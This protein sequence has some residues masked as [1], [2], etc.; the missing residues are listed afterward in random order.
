M[1]P[2]S[3]S[4]L[5]WP[6]SWNSSGPAARGAT[7]PT[8]QL[9]LATPLVLACQP[10]FALDGASAGLSSDAIQ[11]KE[12]LLEHAREYAHTILH[13]LHIPGLEERPLLRAIAQ[14]IRSVKKSKRPR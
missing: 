4:L 11:R 7:A 10:A 14:D 13:T 12:K 3:E 5:N 1:H 2:S 8:W 9:P 6:W